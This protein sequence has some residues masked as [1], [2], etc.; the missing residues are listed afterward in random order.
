MTSV[1]SDNVSELPTL[2]R[3]AQ[4]I[5]EQY[6]ALRSEEG[7][8]GSAI[9]NSETP[10]AGGGGVE[11]LD[12]SDGLA[13]DVTASLH[14]DSSSG[15]Q[16]PKKLLRTL[17]PL[18]FDQA[19]VSP[20]MGRA[21]ASQQGQQHEAPAIPAA[22]AHIMKIRTMISLGEVELELRQTV[23]GLPQPLPL[24]RFSIAELYVAFNNTEGG[25]MHVNVCVPKVEIQDLR[26]EVPKEQS[27]V[28]SSGHKASFLMLQWDATPGLVDQ[29][30]GI[31]LQ[32]P[33]F[34]AELSFLLSIAR[35]VMPSFAFVKS[36]PIPYVSYDV[37]LDGKSCAPPVIDKNTK[38]KEGTAYVACLT[39][40][41]R[42]DDSVQHASSDDDGMP[43]RPLSYRLQKDVWLSPAVRIL[44]DAPGT[45]AIELDGN[46]H[47]LILP[48]RE[49]LN[50]MLPLILVGA[51]RT[52]KLRN[53][54]VVN[55]ESLAACIQLGPGSKIVAQPL[56]GVNFV[57][58]SALSS[59]TRPVPQ[60]QP[61]SPPHSPSLAAS[62]SSSRRLMETPTPLLPP[63]LSKSPSSFHAISPS[64]G[65]ALAVSTPPSAP[66]DQQRSIAITLG[67]VGVSLQLMQLERERSNGRLDGGSSSYLDQA[68]S[69]SIATGR[70]SSSHSLPKDGGREG[71]FPHLPFS[72]QSGD[73]T[74]IHLLSITLDIEAAYTK[75]GDRQYGRV[76]IQGLRAETQNISN[77]EQMLLNRSESQLIEHRKF[78]GKK[79]SEV[80][81]PCKVTLTFDLL[82]APVQHNTGTAVSQG[83]R[84]EGA[85]AHDDHEYATST[86]TRF[87]TT[88]SSPTTSMRMD[89]QGASLYDEAP[90]IERQE[91]EEM[92]IIRTDIN[93][94]VSDIRL[95]LSPTVV[96]LA[97]LLGTSV[98]APLMQPGP[99][100]A[101]RAASQFR[102]VWSFD[103]AAILQEAEQS[104]V[105]V[106]ATGIGT[107]ITVWQ[108]QTASGYGITGHVVTP[109]QSKPSFEV[110]TVA[111]NSG[112][113]AYPASYKRVWRGGGASVWRPVPPEKYVALGDV[114]MASEDR[115]PELSD[116]L[117]VHGMFLFLFC[118][119]YIF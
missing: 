74:A 96:S 49:H 50:E 94:A 84:L 98:L 5:A 63:A 85:G 66:Q 31:T 24:A 83:R 36:S 1:A 82:S 12:V 17:S 25:T 28:I 35:F 111:A 20:T 102:K 91:G 88:M 9:A 61:R 27:L 81:H 14:D 26:P 113:A 6:H 101:V 59:R 18:P 117:C 110:L 34:V 53:V 46:G 107:G 47:R 51:G 115:E 41:E 2:P 116:V 4:W 93:L 89:Y 43:S 106:H 90:A 108:P 52:L 109:G 42:E 16:S 95:T 64:R 33:V 8:S 54:T 48:S 114:F 69:Q 77:I 73:S 62:S 45:A 44:A 55:A 86:L 99:D 119:H 92:Q 22:M 57:D 23:E 40:N 87:D 75:S 68:P 30:L 70:A 103:A 11:S 38:N 67:A 21:T 79:D 3:G 76:D 104:A 105:D 10:A 29:K 80:L 56:D 32:K 118:I 78:R 97:N 37:L 13:F 7:N 112:L 15:L 100:T 72:Q 60:S 19:L 71:L 39:P 65:G 58:S